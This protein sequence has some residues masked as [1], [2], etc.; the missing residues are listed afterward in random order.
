M[1]TNLLSEKKK[2]NTLSSRELKQTV[3]TFQLEVERLHASKEFTESLESL[4]KGASDLIFNDFIIQLE[5]S[6]EFD[7]EQCIQKYGE[8]LKIVKLILQSLSWSLAGGEKDLLDEYILSG[9]SELLKTLEHSSIWYIEALKYVKAHH[10][11]TGEPAHQMNTL[12]DYLINAFK[13]A[14]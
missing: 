9:F 3:E 2:Q 14:T 1:V 12:I 7:S 8:V 10:G 4:A 5:V 13:Q 6:Q 11:L